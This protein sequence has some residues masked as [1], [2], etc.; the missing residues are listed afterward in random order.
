MGILS[1]FE[2]IVRDIGEGI[3]STSSSATCSMCINCKQC[4]KN[5]SDGKQARVFICPAAGSE[6]CKNDYIQ[7]KLPQGYNVSLEYVEAYNK[8][9]EEVYSHIYSSGTIYSDDPY[10]IMDDNYIPITKFDVLRY[11]YKAMECPYFRPF[12]DTNNIMVENDSLISSP[13]PEIED[14]NSLSK[15]DKV[16][17]T[18][19][20]SYNG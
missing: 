4:V 1:F 6:F 15:E 5:L 13:V 18:N 8:I 11:T 19:N 20:H 16:R 2:G 9:R 12:L 3:F 17:L 7:E 14:F 10:P